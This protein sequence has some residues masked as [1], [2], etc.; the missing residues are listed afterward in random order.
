[1]EKLKQEESK[2]PKGTRLLSE[3]ERISTLESLNLKKKKLEE[4]LF[5][6]PIT[7]KTM[8]LQNRKAELEKQLDEV[9]AAINQ[10]SKKKVFI[11]SD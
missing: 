3:E 2:Y 7:M 10:F 1:M 8:S 4:E 6:M 5:K 11:K 9:D